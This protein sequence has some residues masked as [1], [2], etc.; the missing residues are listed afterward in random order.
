MRIARLLVAITAVSSLAACEGRKPEYGVAVFS[1][2]TM[3]VVFTLTVTGNLALSMRSDGFQ[4]QPDKSLL[5]TTPAQL[6]VARSDG[7]ARIQTVRGA[8]LAVQPIGFPPD[9]ADTTT[10][11][12][13]VVVLTAPPLRRIV[14]LKAE[15]PENKSPAP[16][17][18]GTKR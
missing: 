18:P 4:T 2:D 13:R 10:V 16:K 9:S 8:G 17:A 14:T 1:T 11:E 7:T 12:G 6:T 5:L 15:A 3:P